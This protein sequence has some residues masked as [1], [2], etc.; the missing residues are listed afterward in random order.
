MWDLRIQELRRGNR[1][2]RLQFVAKANQSFE[3]SNQTFVPV[4]VKI[5]NYLLR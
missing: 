3:C 1:T 4:N 5:P 2:I